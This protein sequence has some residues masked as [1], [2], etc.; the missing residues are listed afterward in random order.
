MF[1]LQYNC[2]IRNTQENSSGR[3]KFTPNRN[4][5]L[6]KEVKEEKKKKSGEYGF[7]LNVNER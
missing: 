5:N 3:G 1:V 7:C 2:L 4:S 6:F